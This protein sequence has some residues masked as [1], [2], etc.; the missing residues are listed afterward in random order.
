METYIEVLFTSKYKDQLDFIKVLKE[1][2]NHST[3]WE[4]LEDQSKVFA[5]MTGEPSCSIL[6]KGNKYTT[7]A[8][9]I[10]RGNVF[11]ITNIVPKE[12]VRLSIMEYYIKNYRVKATVKITKEEIGL[13]EIITGEKSR[14]LFERYLSQFPTSYHP[15]DIVRLD[16]FICNVSR[17]SKKQIDF[18]LLKSWLIEENGW[19]EKDASWCVERIGVGLDILKVNKKF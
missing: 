1:F 5:S 13:Q 10:K 17:F 6:W 16:A 2:G 11:Y 4:Y 9:T 3:K 18:D 8:I 12:S 19:S 14:Y 7:I 15:L